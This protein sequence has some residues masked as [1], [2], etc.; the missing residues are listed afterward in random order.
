MSVVT[1][2][3]IVLLVGFAG[4]AFVGFFAWRTRLRGTA[5]SP[6]AP[7]A[8]AMGPRELHGGEL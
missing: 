5:E 3:G 6:R 2:L 1:A 8:L 7:H 4:T